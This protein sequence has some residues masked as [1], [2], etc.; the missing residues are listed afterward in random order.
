MQKTVILETSVNEYIESLNE[1]VKNDAL[2]LCDIFSHET[3][4]PPVLWRGNMIGFGTYHYR[5]DTGHEGYAMKCGFAVRKSNITL[6]LFTEVDYKNPNYRDELLYKLGNIKHG[7]SCIYI[8]K[9][10]DIDIDIL[11]LLI[12]RNQFMIE[13]FPSTL[14]C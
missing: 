7:K 5:Y 10:S 11:K 14:S 13:N 6:Y 1:T 4:E 8:K 2:L 9:L 3:N 12:Q